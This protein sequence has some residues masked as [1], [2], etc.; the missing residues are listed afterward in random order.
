[1][2]VSLKLGG[3]DFASTLE[4]DTTRAAQNSLDVITIPYMVTNLYA[5]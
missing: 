4:R 2:R 1:L 5:S 3:Q